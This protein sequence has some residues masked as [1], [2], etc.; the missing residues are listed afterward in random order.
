MKTMD[1]RKI[2]TIKRPPIELSFDPKAVKEVLKR[3]LK[4]KT[5]RILL[6]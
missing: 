3:S 5:Q 2:K 1:C 4:R 6:P